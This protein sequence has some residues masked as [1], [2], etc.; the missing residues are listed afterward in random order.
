M[1]G[2]ELERKWLIDAPPAAALEVPGDAIDQGY[3]AI[4][5]DGSEVR[6][7]RRAETCSLTFK[8]GRGIVRRE[9]EVELDARQFELLWPGTEGRRIEKT[10]RVLEGDRGPE[11]RGRVRIELDLYGGTLA[12]LIVAEVEFADEAGARAFTAPPWFG[13]EVTENEGYKN[14]RLALDGRPPDRH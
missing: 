11:D 12:G 8:S 2:V 9:L 1:S 7:R 13:E 14:R 10:R 3:L 6:L 4:G 5:E